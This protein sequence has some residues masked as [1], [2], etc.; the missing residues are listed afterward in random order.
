MAIITHADLKRIGISTNALASLIRDGRLTRLRH[1]VYTYGELDHGLERHESLVTASWRVVDPTNVL[2]HTSAAALHGL[3][4]RKAC[5]DVVTMT[6]T[7]PGHADRGPHLRVRNT[8]ITDEEITSPEG[9]RITTLAR[10]VSDV[11]RTEPFSWGIAAADAALRTG[12]PR[13]QLRDAV[14]IH[15]RLRGIPKARSIAEL[16][17]PLSESPAESIS[18][19]NMIHAGLPEPQQQAEIHDERGEFV[20]RVDF[21]WPAYGV[22]G[23]VDGAHK[24]GELLRPGQTAQDAVMHEK[25]REEELRGLGYWLFR[26]DW[27]TATD[28]SRLVTVVR[29]GLA[30]GN[31]PVRRGYVQLADEELLR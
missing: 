24:Y 11:A 22:I 28:T 26:W 5:L 20:A 7:T 21:L 23:E 29:R 19:I 31:G 8:R 3:P 14:G 25:A 2:S 4:V 6:R 27:S 16:A 10:T 18:R 9:T 12:L 17:S 30:S 13:E 15:P 1:G